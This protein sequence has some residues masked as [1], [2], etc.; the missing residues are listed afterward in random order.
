MIAEWSQLTGKFKS[1][2]IGARMGRCVKTP[3]SAV[4]RA[5]GRHG[6]GVIGMLL[7]S[8]ISLKIVSLSS[9]REKRVQCYTVTSSAVSEA[10]SVRSNTN[11]KKQP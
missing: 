3:K 11:V 1:P 9:W 5:Q 10:V 4:G 6:G 8:E 7:R 2:T